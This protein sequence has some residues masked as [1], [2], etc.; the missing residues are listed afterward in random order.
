MQRLF[1]GVALDE[2]T[3]SM[4]EHALEGARAE[5]ARLPTFRFLAAESWHFTLQFLGA[6]EDEAVAAVAAACERAALQQA[7][8]ELELSNAGAFSSARKA[9]VL[10]FG[11]SRGGDCM[12]ALHTSL[13]AET[14]SLGFA[15]DEREYSPHLTF[16]RLK[17]P[18]NVERLLASLRLPASSMPVWEITLFRSHLSQQGAR[19]QALGRY[20][21]ALGG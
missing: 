10:W 21:L 9:S 11:V 6:V 16:A 4:I 3:R 19:Y 2:Q 13:L 15:R 12:R 20:P 14:E 18:A 8:F 5:A 7:R 17:Q 1:V